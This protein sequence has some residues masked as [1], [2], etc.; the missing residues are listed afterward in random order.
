MQFGILEQSQLRTNTTSSEILSETIGLAEHAESLGFSKF[1]VT[2]HHSSRFACPS[3]E[4]LMTAIASRTSSISVGCGGIM[5][6]HGHT[7]KTA[8]QLSMICE[9]FPDRIDIGVGRAP[10]AEGSEL[11]YLKKY[12]TSHDFEERFS[13]LRSKLNAKP[14]WVLASGKRSVDFAAAKGAPLCFGYFINPN[15][16]DLLEEYRKK[17]SPGIVESPQTMACIGVIAARTEKDLSDK[18]R[19]F[20]KH[21]IN[22]K[23][24]P[25]S[26][27]PSSV[28]FELSTSERKFIREFLKNEGVLIATYDEI[29][30]KIDSFVKSLKV[31]SCLLS[32]FDYSLRNKVEV[33]NSIA[34]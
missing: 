26:K 12:N 34:T 31:S 17:F 28:N 3:P 20:G 1:W 9:L 6:N 14:P 33:M 4:I 16:L 8:E 13:H 27:I 10:A 25:E 21:A 2:E 23:S 30:N 5:L 15:G 32:I 24:N 7:H 19:I 22:L 18:I 29:R 11:E